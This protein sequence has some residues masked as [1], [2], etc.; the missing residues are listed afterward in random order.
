MNAANSP[1]L[2]LKFQ[3]W[4]SRVLLLVLIGWFAALG[5][6]AL[7]LQGLHHD[8]LQAKGESRY[9]RVITLAAT[10]GVNSVIKLLAEAGAALDIKNKRGQTPLAAAASRRGPGDFDGDTAAA[11]LKQKNET[12]ELLRALG[13]RE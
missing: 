10:R 11:A 13:A 5:M 7:Y 9:S 6:R 4:R 3:N 12:V 2:K 8:F 1:V